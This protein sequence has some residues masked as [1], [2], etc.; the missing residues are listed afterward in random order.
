VKQ[1]KQIIFNPFRLDTVNECL[2][3]GSQA[4][5]LTPKAFAVLQYLVEHPGRLVT[6]EE[7]LDAV[8]PETYVSDAVLKV[9]IR[10]IRKVLGDDPKAPQ[11]IET[12]H[13]R[14]YRFIGEISGQWSVVSGQWSDARTQQLATSDQRPAT[15]V[16]REA[17]LAQLHS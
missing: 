16:G 1:E 10:E 15:I 13:R 3:R 2:W 12:V 5:S 6:K 7:L 11:F 8:W 17:T 9:C 14:G 4:I